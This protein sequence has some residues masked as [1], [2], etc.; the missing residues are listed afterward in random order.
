VVPA[1]P[2]RGGP[3]PDL[4]PRVALPAAPK[5]T[6]WNNFKRMAAQRM[7]AAS[8]KA[9]YT[10]RP[11]IHYAISVLEIELSA[12]GMVRDISVT[13]APANEEAQDTIDMAKAIIRRGEPYG[14]V[15]RLPK[16]WKFTEVFLF[17]DQRKFKPRTLD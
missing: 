16:P 14:D 6:N 2:P 8:P 9:I 10:K 4:G 12:D 11:A 1:A 3:E 17:N 7:V 5:V 13:R 15:S